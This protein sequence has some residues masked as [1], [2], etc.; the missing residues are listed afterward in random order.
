[1]VRGTGCRETNLRVR[2]REKNVLDIPFYR[3]GDYA[4]RELSDTRPGQ[5]VLSQSTTW[6]E[7]HSLYRGFVEVLVSTLMVEGLSVLPVSIQT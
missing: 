6:Q 5:K 7:W 2:R 3:S 1:M 4:H